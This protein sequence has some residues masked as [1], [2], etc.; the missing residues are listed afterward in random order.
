MIR[1]RSEAHSRN[2]TGPKQG[3]DRHRPQ[4]SSAACGT[5]LIREGLSDDVVRSVQRRLE[6]DT[7]TVDSLLDAIHLTGTTSLESPISAVIL[8]ECPAFARR[9]V[10]NAFG[11]GCRG[12]T[13]HIRRPG[14]RGPGG[15]SG[16]AISRVS[17]SLGAPL[18][19]ESSVGW[20]AAATRLPTCPGSRP[21]RS[22]DAGCRRRGRP[23]PVGR[24][25]P[26]EDHSEVE[27]VLRKAREHGTTGSRSAP[28]TWRQAAGCRSRAGE[29][30]ATDQD[31][32]VRWRRGGVR[33]GHPPG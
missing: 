19:I 25:S 31:A 17:A 32:D 18:D 15:G 23:P 20:S 29:R 1:D 7:T 33:A 21:T 11:H 5:L 30:D 3:N 14:P 4:P 13:G 12:P 26:L 2:G 22:R 9:D 10:V 16:G 28:G 6:G 27:R 24:G 8:G